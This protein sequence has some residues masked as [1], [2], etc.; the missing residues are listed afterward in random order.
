MNI[1]L[2]CGLALAIILAIWALY[3]VNNVSAEEVIGLDARIGRIVE[4]YI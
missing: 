3:K 1:A 4:V 2:G